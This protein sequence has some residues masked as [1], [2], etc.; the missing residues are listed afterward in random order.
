MG[1]EA[2]TFH[3]GQ[4]EYVVFEFPL[5]AVEPMPELSVAEREIVG[6]LVEGRSN[7]EIAKERGTSHRTVTNQLRSIYE[8]LGVTGRIELVRRCTLGRS[9]S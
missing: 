6:A 3:V 5:P 2:S 8:K 4:D 9:D 1:L 7:K